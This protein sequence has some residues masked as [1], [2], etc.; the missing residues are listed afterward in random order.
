MTLQFTSDGSVTYP[1][2][3]VRFYMGDKSPGKVIGSNHFGLVD[4]MFLYLVFP[5]SGQSTEKL[6]FSPS[7]G[8]ILADIACDDETLP[9]TLYNE[10]NILETPDYPVADHPDGTQCQW[11]LFPQNNNNVCRSCRIW[12]SLIMIDLKAVSVRNLK[13]SKSLDRFNNLDLRING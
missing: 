5:V 6:L 4:F 1:G 13:T 9:L 8:Q 11:I 10:T 7:V 2:F 12:F 3:N